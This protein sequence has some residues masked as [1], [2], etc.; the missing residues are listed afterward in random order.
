MSSAKLLFVHNS[1][2]NKRLNDNIHP[3][4]IH[5]IQ[6]F[7]PR[8]LIVPYSWKQLNYSHKNPHLTESNYL[9]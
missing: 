9:W 4:T 2:N 5:L 8:N 3:N 7:N 6:D 1:F